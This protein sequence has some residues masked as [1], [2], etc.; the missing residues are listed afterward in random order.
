MNLS[1]PRAIARGRGAAVVPPLRAALWLLFAL[2]LGPAAS[3]AAAPPPAD[4]PPPAPDPLAPPALAV[5]LY[6]TIA[7]DA[8]PGDDPATTRMSELR[9]VRLQG[10][11]LESAQFYARTTLADLT[12]HLPGGVMHGPGGSLLI[13]AA[14]NSVLAVSPDDGRLTASPACA[15]S[16]LSPDALPTIRDLCPDP[17]ADRAWAIS[18]SP[19]VAPLTVAPGY[20]P[21]RALALSGDDTDLTA[22]AFG[23]ITA[24]NQ[25]FQRIFY[26]ARSAP[27]S[28]GGQPIRSLGFLSAL[29]GQTTRFIV[30]LPAARAL[31][32]D[33]FTGDLILAG[34]S[35]IAQADADAATPALVA[36]IDLRPLAG[37]GGGTLDLVD[38]TTDGLGR[39]FAV[40][41]DGRLVV[42]DCSAQEGRVEGP[43]IDDPSVHA[44]VFQ[45]EDPPWSDADASTYPSIRGLAPLSGP[46]HSG[47]SDCLW[48]NGASDGLNG[49]L[50]Q[51]ST[52]HG[53]P[54]TADD[55]YL[56]PGRVYRLDTLTATLASNTVFPKARLEVYTDCNGAPGD[57][58]GAFDSFDLTDTGQRIDD[59]YTVYSARFLL[60]GIFVEGGRDGRALWFA[61]RGVGLGAG[62]E[63]WFW[64]T[65]GNGVVKGRAGMFRSAPAGYPD[66]TPIDGFGC[67]C[68]DFAFQLYGSSCKVLADG[69]PPDVFAE[70]AG[71]LSQIAS[72]ADSAR[73]ADD[74][75]VPPQCAGAQTVCYLKAYVF[76]N[77]T[78]VRGRFEL[79]DDACHTPAGAPGR[80]VRTAVFARVTDLSYSVMLNGELMTLFAVEAFDLDWAL[81]P[82][83][84]YWISPVGDTT[85]SLRKQT[86]AAFGRRCDAPVGRDGRPCLS[87]WSPAVA[88]GR[89][90][91]LTSWTRLADS[92]GT[93]RDLAMVVGVE[94]REHARLL[95]PGELCPA[96]IDRNGEVGLQ[97]LFDFLESWFAGCP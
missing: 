94:N 73:V 50:S 68:S 11:T 10:P 91:G 14:K 9:S 77:C 17:F 80:P 3:F 31:A 32:M 42:L 13:A 26:A 81:T 86:Y 18:Q 89:G 40:S 19:V 93:P 58:I 75:V 55:A 96:D 12:P 5:D 16:G 56:Q 85:Y 20:A 38:V 92:T 22:L 37:D 83:H 29:T 21:G 84:N 61:V 7:T 45:L 69:G 41:A 62:T 27:F 2:L 28:P 88:A 36:A 79:Y 46:G 35:W 60:G 97:D 1:E 87:R 72:D 34:G 48:D 54:E 76:S 53:N 51:V 43:R 52:E 65:A 39:I 57:M 78:P 47:E 74:F 44:R 49:Q 8:P 63:E 71:V 64:Q 30:N 4:P 90:L 95:A 66:W 25:P 6:Y 70:P 33:R 67:G 82:G 23:T 24:N 59:T 15:D